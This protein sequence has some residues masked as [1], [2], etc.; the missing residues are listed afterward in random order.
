MFHGYFDGRFF[1]QFEGNLW[2]HWDGAW[3]KDGRKYRGEIPKKVLTSFSI[4]RALDLVGKYLGDR[5]IS[6]HI[7]RSELGLEQYARVKG[8]DRPFTIVTFS[9]PQI[10]LFSRWPQPRWAQQG[11]E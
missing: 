7:Q 5:P 6:D 11:Q 3:W 10:R 2:T 4:R 1:F 9:D 8:Y